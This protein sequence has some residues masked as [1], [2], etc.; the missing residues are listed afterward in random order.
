[1]SIKQRIKIR[2][3]LAQKI[4]QTQDSGNIYSAT[5]DFLSSPVERR[6]Y[7]EKEK[8]ILR[9]GLKNGEVKD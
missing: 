9:E 2:E 7:T 1:M 3:T 4:A 6:P 5:Y 8:K